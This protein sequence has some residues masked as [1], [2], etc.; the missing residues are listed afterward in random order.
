ME[1]R[2][3]DRTTGLGG[4]VM[5]SR[6]LARALVV[7][8]ATGA[9]LA[10][11]GVIFWDPRFKSEWAPDVAASTITADDLTKAST[12][13]VYFSHMSVG[14]NIM[15]GVKALYA[16]KGLPQPSVVA[17]ERDQGVSAPTGGIVDVKVGDNGHPKWK[18]ATFD[19]GLRA[20]LARNV[21]VAILK[22][23]YVDINWRTNV[24]ETF[25]LYKTTLDALEKDFPNVR[26]LHSTV[27]L[28]VGPDGIKDY[29]KAVI[30]RDDNDAR[31][32][33]NAL[34]RAAY[35]AEQI[36]V[37]AASESTAPDG[38]SRTTLDPGYSDDGSHLNPS[39][40]SLVASVL[41]KKLAAMAPA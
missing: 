20:G 34:L 19:R 38:A 18:L 12:V 33:Y 13:T 22:F 8:A 16:A 27:P 28:R 23:C 41:L 10:G 29:I 17:A 21:D 30:G 39:G 14:Q 3:N 15:S 2:Y 24:E 6:R 26:F 37:V 32:R 9:V 1:V 35:P 4:T 7:V 31:N 40:S 36:F 5:K 25:N 11:V